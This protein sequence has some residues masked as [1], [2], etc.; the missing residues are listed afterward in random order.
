[1]TKGFAHESTA[2]TVPVEWYT[3]R[4]IFDAL[5]I[6]FDLDPCSA[7][8]PAYDSVPAHTKY[9]L[10]T[11]GLAEPWHGTVWVNPPY[12]KHTGTWVKKLADHGDGIALVFARPDTAWFQQAY[13]TADVVCFVERRI[14]FVNGFTGKADGTPGAGSALIGYG[15]KA[16]NAIVQSGLGIC[17]TAIRGDC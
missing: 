5:G 12:G 2:T 4:Y 8:A 9:T 7:C 6:T 1:M 3:P 11:D 16:Y 15:T 10:P 14:K 13:R 17:T